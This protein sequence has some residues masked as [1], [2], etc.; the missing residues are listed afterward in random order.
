MSLVHRS[1]AAAARLLGRGGLEVRR[2]P[3]T[4]RQRMLAKHGVDLVIDV[5]AASGG[6]ATQLRDFGWT[7][8][9]ESFEPLSDAFARLAEAAADD[10][11][12]G[13][14]HH[15]LGRET[16]EARIN[17]ASNSDSSS[18]LPMLEAHRAA[19]PQVSY[20]GAETIAVRRLDDVAAGFTARRAFLKVDTQ[21][22]ERDV[23]AGAADTLRRCVGLQLELSFIP[24]YDGGMLAD[25]AIGWAY[26]HGFHVVGIEQ[27]Y[28]APDGELLQVDAVFVRGAAELEEGV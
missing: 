13:V 15:A 22:F 5:G 8:R 25:E 26:D 19:A 21:G 2:H 3:A 27:G 7:G 12:W 28:A 14:H 20:V 10:P 16:G 4:R 24:L 18:M 9:I 23:L 11:A 17:V 6:Y 1:A